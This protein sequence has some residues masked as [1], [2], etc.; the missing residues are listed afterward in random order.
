[1]DTVNLCCIL[2]SDPN[3]YVLYSFYSIYSL[4]STQF[5][6]TL[7]SNKS[8]LLALEIKIQYENS[9]VSRCNFSPISLLGMITVEILFFQLDKVLT[10]S[11]QSFNMDSL[12]LDKEISSASRLTGPKPI[13]SLKYNICGLSLCFKKLILG[14]FVS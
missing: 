11:Q 12:F 3:T 14:S 9:P 2:F 7:N 4:N 5:Y 10:D 1:M 13:G 8:N 6:I